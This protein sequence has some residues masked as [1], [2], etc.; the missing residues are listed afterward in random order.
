MLSLTTSLLSTVVSQLVPLQLSL[1]VQH[2]GLTSLHPLFLR[3]WCLQALLKLPI[4]GLMWFPFKNIISLGFWAVLTSEL[5]SQFQQALQQ[6]DIRK[7]RLRRGARTTGRFGHAMLELF[8]SLKESPE[9][10]LFLFGKW[11]TYV[12]DLSSSWEFPYVIDTLFGSLVHYVTVL[13][14]EDAQSIA[15][16]LRKFFQE[17]KGDEYDMLDDVLTD[18]KNTRKK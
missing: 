11:T 12:L 5:C 15:N 4:F 6:N 18:V 8:R 1:E 10:D 3:Y 9:Q 7:K 16:S 13:Q 14:K 17:R 2:M